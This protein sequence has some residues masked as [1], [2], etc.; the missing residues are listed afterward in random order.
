M[1]NLRSYDDLHG[2]GMIHSF[3]RWRIAGC[4]D[5]FNFLSF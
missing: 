5:R 2:A 1:R 4:L 3:L